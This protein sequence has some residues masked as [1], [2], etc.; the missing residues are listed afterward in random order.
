MASQAVNSIDV[1]A[2]DSLSL[3]LGKQGLP[4]SVA[5]ALAVAPYRIITV[6]QFANFFETKPELK[7]FCDDN[8]DIFR[9]RGDYIAGFTQRWRVAEPATQRALTQPDRDEA[10]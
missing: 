2:V 7:L 3:L 8:P 6:S 4:E 1:D 10:K 5:E 9:D